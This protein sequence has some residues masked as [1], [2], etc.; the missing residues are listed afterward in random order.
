MSLQQ[1]KNINIKTK[2]WNKDIKKVEVQY[3][4]HDRGVVIRIA[5]LAFF[6]YSKMENH[7]DTEHNSRFV[8]CVLITSF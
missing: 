7:W 8:N 3:N 1:Q 4:E 5:I 6:N 2:Q